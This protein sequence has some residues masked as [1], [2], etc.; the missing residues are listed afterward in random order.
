MLK[1][2]ESFRTEMDVVLKNVFGGME[3]DRFLYLCCDINGNTTLFAIDCES[4][5]SVDSAIELFDPEY[6]D[7]LGKYTY[8]T[9][10]TWFDKRIGTPTKMTVSKT[11]S[12]APVIKTEQ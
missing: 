8:E 2:M 12:I 11:Y 3:G 6:T 9:V 1:A 5:E 7:F 4:K 10:Y